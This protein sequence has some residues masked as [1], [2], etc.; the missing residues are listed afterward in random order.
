MKKLI[1]VLPIIA[2][3]AGCARFSASLHDVSTETTK[4]GTIVR[5]SITTD[6]KGSALFSSS[7]NIARLKAL[8]TDKTQSF[9]GEGVNQKGATNT[10]EALKELNKMLEK[11]SLP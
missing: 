6:L 8:Q 9:G 3:A 1:A 5:R 4:A 2:L 11:I 7:Q 10:V